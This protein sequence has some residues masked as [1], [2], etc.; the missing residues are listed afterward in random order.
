MFGKYGLSGIGTGKDAFTD[1]YTT[2]YIGNSVNVKHAHS[3][4]F[5]I[6][7]SLGFFGVV[8]FA[9]IIFFIMQGAL[10]Y[11]RNCTDKSA[12]NRLLCY[13]GMCSVIALVL[14]GLTEYIWLNSRIMLV[15]WILCGLAVCSRRSANER[16]DEEQFN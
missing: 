10:T 7:F 8:L 2:F 12:E 4:L 1:I 5:Q 9:L 6:A 14:C 15:F 16:N 11:G 3:L 13:S